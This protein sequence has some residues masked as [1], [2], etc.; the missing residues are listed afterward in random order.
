VLF[1]YYKEAKMGSLLRN[2]NPNINNSFLI[3]KADF[4]IEEE[5]CYDF[6]LCC[7]C[8]LL[9]L[10]IIFKMRC[11]WPNTVAHIVEL[12]TSNS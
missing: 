5:L 11:I 2:G 4:S 8:L 10:R 12:F 1:L 6:Q 9:L 7:I 3:S